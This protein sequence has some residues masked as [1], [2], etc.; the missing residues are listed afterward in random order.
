MFVLCFCSAQKKTPEGVEG[1]CSPSG[2]PR[3]GG[4][5][6][7]CQAQATLWATAANVA[8]SSEPITGTQL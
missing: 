1:E 6:R 5:G 7:Q 2:R 3:R 4:A 8:P